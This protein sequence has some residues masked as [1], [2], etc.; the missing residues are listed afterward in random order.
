MIASLQHVSHRYGAAT[1]LA[2]VTSDLPAGTMVG[3]IGPD[4]VGKSTLLGLVAGARRIQSGRVRV[5][6]GDMADPR[7]RGAA[8]PRIAYMPQGLGKNLYP[9]DIEDAVGGVEG[10]IP[11]RVVAFGVESEADGTE[12][13][14][15]A[16]ETAVEE[17]GARKRLALA[18]KQAAMAI[19][20]TV[21]AVHLVPPRWLIKSSSGKPSRKANRERVLSGDAPILEGG[22]S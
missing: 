19:D 15:V 9:E 10:V 22:A 11:G 13:V 21:A 12:Q 7:H 3:L 14:C 2:D 17:A 6:G 4:G 16:A 8:C 5:L 18:V 1:A 20:V